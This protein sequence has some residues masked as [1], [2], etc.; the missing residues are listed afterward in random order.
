[1]NGGRELFK[2][3]C[4]EVWQLLTNTGLAGPVLWLVWIKDEV[5]QAFIVGLLIAGGF[6]SAFLIR[7]TYAGS[8]KYLG[9]SDKTVVGLNIGV[10]GFSVVAAGL[11]VAIL[12]EKQRPA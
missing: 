3:S 10:L 6:L 4:C 11:V 8:M 2:R 12:L 5:I 7:D 9:G 1:L